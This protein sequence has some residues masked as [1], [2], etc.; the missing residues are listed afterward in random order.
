M[1]AIPGAGAKVDQVLIGEIGL[2]MSAFSSSAHLACWAGLCPGNQAWGG[3]R[4]GGRSRPGSKW[5]KAA[6]TESGV[7]RGQCQGH[8]PAR[9]SRADQR[10][11]GRLQDSRCDSPR[12]QRGLLAHRS[13][14][15]APPGVGPRPGGKAIHP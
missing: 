12:H 11:G 10:L 13:R 2:D 9:A 6:L 15:G 7:G 1:Q 5:L 8:L 4:R 14:P 3:K